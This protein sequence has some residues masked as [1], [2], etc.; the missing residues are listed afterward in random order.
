M[1]EGG[2]RNV[3]ASAEG[4]GAQVEEKMKLGGESRGEGITGGTRRTALG[5][6]GKGK[7]GKGGHVHWLSGCGRVE[8]APLMRSRQAS[9]NRRQQLMN[10]LRTSFLAW[11]GGKEKGEERRG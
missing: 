6:G 3:Q 1:V 2:E 4:G 8:K 5:R 10:S 11:K 7:G 9:G